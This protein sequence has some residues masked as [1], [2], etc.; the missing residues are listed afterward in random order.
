MNIIKKFGETGKQSYI[1]LY[2]QSPTEDY[3]LPDRIERMIETIHT[4]GLSVLKC[5]DFY[6]RHGKMPWY[7]NGRLPQDRAAGEKEY[8]ELE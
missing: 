7:I 1:T 2:T 4:L 3:S 6:K 5:A 8:I